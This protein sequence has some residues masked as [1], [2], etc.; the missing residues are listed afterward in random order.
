MS[1]ILLKCYPT[2][3]FAQAQSHSLFIGGTSGEIVLYD[4]KALKGALIEWQGVDERGKPGG[5]K[6]PLIE[7]RVFVVSQSELG[8]L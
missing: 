8:L 1:K 3:V 4:L 7:P 2:N 6:V 5:T